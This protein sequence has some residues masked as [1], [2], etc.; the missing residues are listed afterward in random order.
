ML[1]LCAS[2]EDKYVTVLVTT[3]DVWNHFCTVHLQHY[4]NNVAL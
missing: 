2:F 3:A 1:P 4:S